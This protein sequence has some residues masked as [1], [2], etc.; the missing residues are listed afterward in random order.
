M[1]KKWLL[2]LLALCMSVSAFA[3]VGCGENDG[4]NDANDGENT[5][6]SGGTET[7][8]SYTVTYEANGGLFDGGATSITA[9]VGENDKLTAP[10]PPTRTGYSFIGWGSENGEDSWD[11][12]TDTVTEI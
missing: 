3:F 1:K 9:T 12:A 10:E 4:E 6:Q 5:E 2:G 8:V 7:P 11:F